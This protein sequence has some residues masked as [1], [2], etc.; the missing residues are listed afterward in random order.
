MPDAAPNL[1]P[2]ETM[3]LFRRVHGN[4]QS[5]ATEAQLLL[6]AGH[7]ARAYAL[8]HLAHEELAK[9]LGLLNIWVLQLTAGAPPWELFWRKWRQHGFKVQ[10]A[11]AGDVLRM[12]VGE[13]AVAADESGGQQLPPDLDDRVRALYRGMEVAL[14][15]HTELARLR[16]D[17]TYV[18]FR[19]GKI[20]LPTD[21]INHDMASNMVEAAKLQCHFL[22]LIDALGEDKVRVIA[23]HTAMADIL[24]TWQ[25][26]AGDDRVAPG[27]TPAEAGHG[28]G[29][30]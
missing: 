13:Q 30:R 14:P 19:E 3:E 27:I 8:G 17:A 29:T 28:A 15:R 1:S 16:A 21:V 9:C 2:D 24:S 6:Q 4:A 7:I 18:D 11:L 22:A 26:V 5:L 12:W 20:V 10:L 23:S 25:R